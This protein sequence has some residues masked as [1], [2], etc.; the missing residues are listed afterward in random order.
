[1]VSSRRREAILA[2]FGPGSFFGEGCLTERPIRASTATAT[3]PSTVVC[4]SKDAMRR[5]LRQDPALRDLFTAHLLSRNVRI[6]EDLVDQLFNPSEQRLARL[7]LLLAHTGDAS[8]PETPIHGLSQESLAEMIG[9][10]RS[11]VSHFMNRF[12][13]MGF[14][15]YEPGRIRVHKG[16]LTVVLR[17]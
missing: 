17:D 6:E 16:L 8:T 9:A 7:L 3:V 14:V 2:L 1:M 10:T 4:I 15:D 11:R 13:R 5:R 12:R